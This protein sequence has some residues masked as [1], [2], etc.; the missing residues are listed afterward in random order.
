MFGLFVL[1]V[2]VRRKD[3][4]DFVAFFVDHATVVDPEGNEIDLTFADAPDES[5]SEESDEADGQ[6]VASEAAG[7]NDDTNPTPEAPPEDT[8]ESRD[9]ERSEA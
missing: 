7:S 9:D 2:L 3:E 1:G 6:A 5:S 8:H 4:A